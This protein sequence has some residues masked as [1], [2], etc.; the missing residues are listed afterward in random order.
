MITIKPEGLGEVQTLL[1][2]LEKIGKIRATVTYE[3]RS[4]SDGRA[5]NA[6]VLK[7]HA[8]GIE[9]RN[10]GK[11]VRDV[12]G[13]G[14]ELNDK[15]GKMLLTEIE[16]SIKREQRTGILKVRKGKVTAGASITKTLKGGQVKTITAQ[17]K[18]A[19]IIARAFKQMA[20]E[21]KKNI[22]ELIKEQK[23]VNGAALLGLEPD[24]AKIKK[25][26]HGRE[27]PILVATG[28]LLDS[29]TGDMGGIR[30][31]AQ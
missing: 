19:S 23:D 2:M 18:S 29:V 28:E 25:A 20:M 1:K 24:Y 13:P 31:K 30:F 5:S 4:R 8:E 22:S 26:K 3:G 7:G 9:T 6:E 16:R 21:W 17:K 15:L 10:H 11:K 27:R 12:V 14:K